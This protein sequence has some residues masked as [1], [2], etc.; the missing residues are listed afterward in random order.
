[1]KPLN[2]PVA[3]ITVG[4]IASATAAGP[5]VTLESI[6]DAYTL[7]KSDTSLA[8]AE[9]LRVRTFACG[10]A[11]NAR[12][13]ASFQHDA[14]AMNNLLGGILCYEDDTL[15]PKVAEF[16]DRHGVVLKRFEITDL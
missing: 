15:P 10:S 6:R 4:A 8:V 13:T 12:I 2:T 1:M 7:I 11:V 9:A 16:R 14:G 3:D 5:H